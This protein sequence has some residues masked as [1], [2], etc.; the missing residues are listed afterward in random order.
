M[1][2]KSGIS[3]FKTRIF[4]LILVKS[5]TKISPNKVDAKA[6]NHGSFAKDLRRKLTS[7]R[8]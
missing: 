7:G 8:T 2:I 1:N 4:V 3:P 5:A 6:C